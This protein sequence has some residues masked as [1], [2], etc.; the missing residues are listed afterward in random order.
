MNATFH[1]NRFWHHDQIDSSSYANATSDNVHAIDHELARLNYS[2]EL[3]KQSILYNILR[4]APYYYFISYLAVCLTILFVKTC[5]KQLDRNSSYE[6]LPRWKYLKYNLLTSSRSFDA[7]EQQEYSRLFRCLNSLI[8]FVKEHVYT[9]RPYFRYSKLI[10]C[11]YVSSFTLVYYFTFWIQD[12]TYVFTKKLL[13]FS[14]LI[15]CG[16]ADLSKDLCYTLNLDRINQDI[17]YICLLT[18]LITYVQLFSGMKHYQ[19]QMCQAYRGVFDDIPQ[20]KQVA[21]GAI[22]SRSMHYP[23]RFMGMS[24]K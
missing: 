10:V 5:L 1:R 2:L 12:H 9:I 6:S 11:I 19:R 8:C 17:K 4:N 24:D 14:N 18:A 13:L 22:I 16:L 15:L 21:S 20:P 23:G 7:R 3:N